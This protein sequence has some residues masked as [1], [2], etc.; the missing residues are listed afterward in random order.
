MFWID[1][2][3]ESRV[4]V[5]APHEAQKVEESPLP[6]H[7]ACH[8]KLKAVYL[9]YCTCNRTVVKDEGREEHQL[10]SRQV[11]VVAKCSNMAS[12]NLQNHHHH[13]H[14]GYSVT[15][16][17]TTT[18]TAM[19]RTL[20][21]RVEGPIQHQLLVG[22]LLGLGKSAI[23]SIRFASDIKLNL[24]TLHSTTNICNMSGSR[25]GKYCFK[26][27]HTG[28]NHFWSAMYLQCPKIRNANGFKL[29]FML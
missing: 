15:G 19:T 16:N 18:T 23:D 7:T 1:R 29:L 27:G 20:Q 11:L 24:P 26:T 13:H 2:N 22:G 4:A 9:Q 21:Q 12:L 28:L 10:Q 6:Q 5:A 3:D 25:A 17:A 8:P 14:P